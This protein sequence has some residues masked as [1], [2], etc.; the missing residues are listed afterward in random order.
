[1]KK[2]LWIFILFVSILC[3]SGC[4]QLNALVN[5]YPDASPV[6]DTNTENTPS[7]TP[8]EE[9]AKPSE[10]QQPE[11]QIKDLFPFKENTKYIYEGKGSEY[12]SFTTWVDYI[13][14]NRMQLRKNNGGTEVVQVLELAEGALKR[15]FFKEECYY[16]EDFT[17]K[18]GVNEEILIKEPLMKG[19]TWT[20]SDGR[21]RTISNLD[22]PI[23]TP[24][25]SFK[26]LEVTTTGTDEAKVID[27]YVPNTGLVKT[28]STSNGN[29]VTSTLTSISSSTNTQGIKFFY[30]NINDE[31]IYYITK[32]LSFHTNDL[33]K[34]EIEKVFKESPNKDLAKLLGPAT[35]IKSLYLNKD[36][37]VYVDF[38]KDLVNEMNAGSNTEEMILQCIT[39]TIGEYYGVTKVYI[40]IDGKPYSSGHIVMKKGEAFTVKTKDCSELKE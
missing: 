29:E 38:T 7:V 11:Y 21:K 4:E 25:G 39:N 3:F 28:V 22:V 34:I 1:M 5:P 26:A 36:N 15:K 18:S 33:T 14:E 27:Y 13:K 30:P 6:S 10:N 2:T 37:M 8:P 40:T 17:S 12:A 35:K 20:L 9:E 19:N 31:K 32:N 23:T 24:L 16:R